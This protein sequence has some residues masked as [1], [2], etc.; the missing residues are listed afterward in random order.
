MFYHQKTLARSI[1][2]AESNIT[3]LPGYLGFM[4]LARYHNRGTNIMNSD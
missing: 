1:D 2:N 3:S 4:S